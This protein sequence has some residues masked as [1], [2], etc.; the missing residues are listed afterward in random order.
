MLLHLDALVIPILE[1]V[2]YIYLVT[3]KKF[4]IIHYK[5]IIYFQRIVIYVIFI[6]VFE[7]VF[8]LP[9]INDV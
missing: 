4:N 6:R 7:K 8:S 1:N 5:D 9:L 3:L 2:W